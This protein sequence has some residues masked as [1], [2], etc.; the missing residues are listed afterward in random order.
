LFR[1]ESEKSTRLAEEFSN[2]SKL[3]CESCEADGYDFEV[4]EHL[5]IPVVFI[6]DKSSDL[7]EFI[8]KKE[9][10]SKDVRAYRRRYL[11]NLRFVVIDAGDFAF[12]QFVDEGLAGLGAKRLEKMS[13]VGI[14]EGFVGVLKVK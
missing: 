4:L 10:D 9:K 6:V 12:A 3:K 14:K 1:S 5:N 13:T 11:N 2:L 8:V 7:H